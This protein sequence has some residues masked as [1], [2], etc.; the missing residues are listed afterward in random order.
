M[1]PITSVTPDYLL[2]EDDWAI[3]EIEYDTVVIDPRLLTV[4]LLLNAS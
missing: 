1:E 3:L 2:M 4:E